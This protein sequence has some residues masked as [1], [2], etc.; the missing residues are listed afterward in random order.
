MPGKTINTAAFRQINTRKL[1]SDLILL[2][3][4]GILA[5]AALDLFFAPFDIAPSGASGLAVILNALIGTPIGLMVLII[6]IPIQYLAYRM[7]GGWY[8]IL[9][10]GYLLVIYTT[11]ID[12]L[13][14]YLTTTG[15]TNDRLLSA[16]FGG[17]LGG[18]AG[19]LV[20]RAGGSFGGTSTLALILQKKIGTAFNA[21]YLYTDGFTVALAGLVFGWESALYAIVAIYLDGTAADYVLEGP[22]TIRTV[23]IIT[24]KP[25]EIADI[26]ITQMEHGVTAWTG[27]GMYTN[28]P[29]HILFVTVR[30]PEVSLLRQLVFS[31]D[32]EAFIV[33]GQGHSAYGEGFHPPASRLAQRSLGRDTATSA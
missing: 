26:I 29:R 6:N 17:I 1:I 8:V 33:V 14:P 32:P 20:Y 12:Q 16:I 21:T 9:K 11:A 13:A 4:G 27:T 23:T 18:I 19:G 28:K 7:L 15:L 3:T 25:R 31:L 24:N 30:R 22:S 5:G 2:T 10:T